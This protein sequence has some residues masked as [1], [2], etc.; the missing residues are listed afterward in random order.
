MAESNYDLEPV[1]ALIKVLNGGVE[2]YTEAKKKLDDI[3][4]SRIFDQMIVDKAQAISDLQP[5]VLIDE[6]EIE[7]DTALSVDIRES[8]TKLVG[9]VSTDKAHTYISQLEE[10]EDKVL[11]KLDEALSKTLPPKCKSTLLQIQV[12]MQACHD[13]MK[14]L[15]ELTA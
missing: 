6:G 15:Q 13:Q 2:F 4:L 8:Y 11:K 7:T 3:E 12:R 5:F 1:K 10:V 14:Q 9:M